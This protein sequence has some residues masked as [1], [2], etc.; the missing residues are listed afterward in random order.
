V[1]QIGDEHRF[2]AEQGG[3]NAL[4]SLVTWPVTM[5]VGAYTLG[6]AGADF[7][8][9]QYGSG[10]QNLLVGGLEVFG[11]GAY[12]AGRM[13]GLGGGTA[14]VAPGGFAYG[15][16]LEPLSLNTRVP[17]G[18][19]SALDSIYASRTSMGGLFPELTGINPWYVENAG[20]GVNTNCVSCVNAAHARLT[21]TDLNAV[22]VRAGYSNPNGLLPSAP[23]GFG[24]TT[25]SA[26]VVNEMLQAGNGATRPLIILQPGN[27]WH[28][29]NVVNRN[30]QVYFVDPQIGQI[31]IP[32]PNIPVQ[33]GRPGL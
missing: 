12:G 21:G 23:F 4:A 14:A 7:R 30:G 26:A 2:W 1:V 33:L 19:G 24:Q 18:V 15:T 25:T 32:R 11:A 8:D 9:G 27:V 10:F 31:V 28:V 17:G 16:S 6:T 13:G 20:F 22:A 5:A 29:I 3:G